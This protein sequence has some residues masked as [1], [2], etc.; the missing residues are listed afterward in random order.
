M[1]LHDGAESPSH[2]PDAGKV[3]VDLP[4]RLATSWF[5]DRLAGE[6]VTCE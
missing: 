1:S 6:T 3:T 5:F 2:S 4:V